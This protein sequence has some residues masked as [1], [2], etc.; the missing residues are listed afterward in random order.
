MQPNYKSCFHYVKKL[1]TLKTF[2]ILKVHMSER[3]LSQQQCE[4][5]NTNNIHTNMLMRLDT[6]THKRTI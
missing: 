2:V 1:T 5:K 3:R 4:K 6:H